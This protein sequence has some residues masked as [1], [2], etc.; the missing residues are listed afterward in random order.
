MI[1]SEMTIQQFSNDYSAIQQF[2]NVFSAI[3]QLSN[4]FSAIQ[5]FSNVYSAIVIAELLKRHW[6][7]MKCHSVIPDF[8]NEE[9]GS[10]RT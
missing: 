5:Q 2:S 10:G 4:V 9:C 6:N 8:V 7:L 1:F 3:Q